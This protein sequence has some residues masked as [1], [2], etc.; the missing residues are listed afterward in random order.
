MCYA[1]ERKQAAQALQKSEEQLRQLLAHSP[2]VIYKLQ[3]NGEKITPVFVSENIER[4]LGFEVAESNSNDWWIASL[5]PKDRDRVLDVVRQGVAGQGYS[6]EYRLRH[7]DG[8]YRWVQDDNRVTGAV[9]GLKEAVGVWTDITERKALEAQVISR[10][11]RLN[12]FFQGATVG[13]ALFDMDLRYLQINEALAEMNGVAA[14]D[15]LGRT[16]REVLPELAPQVEPIFHQVLLTGKPALNL[17]IA[18][19]THS[20]P[21]MQRHWVGSIFPV[22]GKDGTPDGAG[23]IVVEVTKCKQTED[24]LRRSEERYRTLAESAQDAIFI[25]NR[26]FRLEYINQAGARPL[27]RSPSELIGMSIMELFPVETAAQQKRDL[28]VVFQSGTPLTVEEKII[29]P[30]A[31]LWLNIQLIPLRS[32]AGELVRV[33]GIG[34][35]I[36]ERKQAEE[37]L[38]ESQAMLA[39]AEQFSHIMVTLLGLDGRWLKVPPTL[40]DLLGYTES[41][42]LSRT[43]G[44]VTAPD[45]RERDWQQYQKL[46]HSDLKTFNSTKRYLRKNGQKVWVSVNCT[47]VTSADGKPVQFLVYLLDVTE[48]KQAE[49]KIREQAAL[50]DQAQEAITVRD[51]EGCILY[52]NRGAERLYG[53]SAG[54][55][56]GHPSEEFSSKGQDAQ[57]SPL[58][59]H[60]L[61]WG[62]RSVEMNKVTKSGRKLVVISH[63]TLIRD[64]ELRPKAFLVI[65]TDVTEQK[66]LE[67]HFLRAQRMESLGTLASGVAHDLNNV[68]APILMTA[69]LLRDG[70]SDPATQKL[71]C[72]VESNAERGADIVRQLL[73]FGRGLEVERVLLNP[74]HLVKEMEKIIG[75]TFPKN[76]RLHATIGKDLWPVCANATQIQ[77]VL[78]NLCINARDAMPEGGDLSLCAENQMVDENVVIVTPGATPGPHVVLKI[79]DTGSGIPPQVL[80]RIFEP[81]FTT[82][83]LG[84]GTGLGLSTVLGIAKGHG[85]FITV[86]SQMGR[87]TEFSV[88]FPATPTQNSQQSAPPKGE[89]PRGGGEL[90]LVVDD[91][92]AVRNVVEGTLTKAGYRFI[93]APDGAR[94][95]TLYAIH[96]EEVKVVLTDLAMPVMD[97]LVLAQNLRK[98]APHL[99]IIAATG[100]Q[101]EVEA[102]QLKALGIEIILQ[103]PFSIDAMLVAVGQI[104]SKNSNPDQAAT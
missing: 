33:L 50:L 64:E 81:F 6:I 84:K 100:L 48:K 83:K 63:W 60:A 10:E 20:N 45:D 95:L 42:L 89:A 54:E 73:V 3:I 55:V 16:I 32:P 53:W 99:K 38:C 29:F 102:E 13:L 24:A 34:R 27:G 8:T 85:G 44:D 2:A 68:L 47:L 66:K 5:H 22:P 82:K 49:D 98:V 74:R 90:I 86:D 17:E 101:Q 103:K 67:A 94:A 71:L 23:S 91:E 11:Q 9:A 97:G 65:D 78:I 39:R 69:S 12:A 104:L 56:I 41:E 1:I 59:R 37:K 51:L 80:D 77:Q 15:H 35:D 93:G 61:K 52:C 58:P 76:I 75:E 7:K 21:E 28:E 87:G 57:L 43:L 4:L 40:C 25:V 62:E 18:G 72:S 88:F 96:S 14:K 36:S 46:L 70:C 19:R 31:A 26:Q 79:R 92:R 30:Q